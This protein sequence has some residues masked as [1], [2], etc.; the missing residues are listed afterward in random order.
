MKSYLVVFLLF[1]GLNL[2]AQPKYLFDNLL[3]GVSY[4]YEYMPYERLEKD[5]QMMKDCG[6]SVVRIAE[7]TWGCLEPQDGVFNFS[8]VDKTLDVMNK[9]GIKVIVGTPTYAIPAWMARKHPEILATTRTGKN[10]YGTRQ[11]MDITNKKYLFYAERVIRRLVAHVAHHPAV[12]GY[13]IDNETK[14]YGTSGENVQKAF[15]DYVK[16]KFKTT[17]SLNLSWG[18]NYWSNNITNWKDFPSANGAVNASMGSEFSRYQRKLVTDFLTWQ[19]SIVR[20]LRRPEQFITQNFDLE[21]REGSYGWQTEVD[22]FAAAKCLDIAGIDIYHKTQDDLDGVQIS[23]GGDIARS[24]KQTN[25]L[26]LETQSQS[27]I[28]STTQHIPYPGQLRLQ[29]F[30]HFACGANMVSYWPWHSIHN[31]V[32]TYWKGL[33]S[34]DMEP[35]PVY[36]EAKT[37]GSDINGIGKSLFN[38]KKKNR[39]AILASNESITALKWFDFSKKYNYNDILHQCYESLYRINIECDFVVPESQNLTDYQLIIVPP[40]YVAT[41]AL[42]GRLNDFAK[43]GGHLLYAFKSGFANENLQVRQKRMPAVIKEACGVS[44]Q[45]FNNF[46]TIPLKD[47]PFQV[48]QSDNYV[49]EWGELLVP[50]NARVLAYYDH[51]YWGK[52]AAITQ[53]N[54]GKGIVTYLGAYPS[55]PVLQKLIQNVVKTA[56]LWSTEQKLAFPLIVKKGVNQQGEKIYYI[57][58]Y[59]DQPQEFVYPFDNGVDL[60]TKKN[61]QKE[62]KIMLKEW[63]FLIVDLNKS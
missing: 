59:S 9:Y 21:W 17:D 4:Y 7:S 37:I 36:E 23:L 61:I 12:I 8:Y 62:S 34:H 13:Q 16:T 25:Y 48:N 45:Q 14:H 53:N 58:N 41:D 3:Y 15:Q 63:G 22:Q 42:L 44:Y 26:V 38:L 49:M 20:E 32:E 24:L 47:N 30:S 33:L 52:Y 60:L 39:V 50:E 10:V 57:F 11:N 35:N 27:I 31:S 2:S 56:G 55:F 1:C 5:A 29:A 46:E 19:S 18:L 51:K 43:N 6:I 54:Y 40:L 28:N